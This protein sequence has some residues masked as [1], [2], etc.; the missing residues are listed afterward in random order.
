M[1]LRITRSIAW[2]VVAATLLGACATPPRAAPTSPPAAMRAD[3]A[4]GGAIDRERPGPS[5]GLRIAAR[6][7]SPTRIHPAA[8]SDRS[9]DVI[10]G[11]LVGAGLLVIGVAVMAVLSADWGDFGLHGGGIGGAMP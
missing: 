4:S 5:R 2:L 11:V 1:R 9:S 8:L 10:V 7:T 3:A 6:P